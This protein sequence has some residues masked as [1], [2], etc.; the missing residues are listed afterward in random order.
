MAERPDEGFKVTDRRRR[1]DEASGGPHGPRRETSGGA[2]P[3]RAPETRTL[4]DLFLMLG[5]EAAVALGDAPD[6]VTGQ[7]QRLL[8]QAAEIIDL[9]LLLRDKTEGNRSA[10]ETQVL[11]ELLYDLQLRYV[12]ATKSAG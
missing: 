6:P 9:L 4:A 11:E 3:V 10:D 1:G 7:R 12:R 2:Q 5:A 8:P